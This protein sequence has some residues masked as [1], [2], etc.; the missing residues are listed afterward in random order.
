MHVCVGLCICVCVCVH[1]RACA[2]VNARCSASHLRRHCLDDVKRLT[3]STYMFMFS[4]L[5]IHYIYFITFEN[6]WFKWKK[7][8]KMMTALSSRP[9]TATTAS[10]W[11]AASGTRLSRGQ[12]IWTGD[13]EMAYL[14]I[15][16]ILVEWTVMNDRWMLQWF[17]QAVAAVVMAIEM[18]FDMIHV[19]HSQRW[20]SYASS[21][22]SI[23]KVPPKEA[24]VECW[25]ATRQA[26]NERL[27]N[28]KPSEVLHIPIIR[29]SSG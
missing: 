17:W 12:E 8:F 5:Y 24:V 1:F 18:S 6:I 3:K 2:R 15:P 21:S 4:N 29:C 26:S 14:C 22:I 16:N 10:A 23:A 19:F 7:C 20:S 25:P 9:N 11:A 27:S 13:D 28:R